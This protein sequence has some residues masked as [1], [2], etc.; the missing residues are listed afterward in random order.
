MLASLPPLLARIATCLATKT[1]AETA[2]ELGIPRGTLYE[3]MRQ[4]KAAFQRAGLDGYL[5]EK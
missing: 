3:H 4:I 1:A 2:R 5:I